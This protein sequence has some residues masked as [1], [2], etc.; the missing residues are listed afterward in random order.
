MKTTCGQTHKHTDTQ[1]HKHTGAD[2]QIHRHKHTD[3]DSETQRY[4]DTYTQTDK[5][6]PVPKTEIFGN[7]L[8][9]H[10]PIPQFAVLPLSQVREL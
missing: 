8:V 10:I 2:T 9:A 7:E 3:T 1:T 6:Q 4:T 5:V